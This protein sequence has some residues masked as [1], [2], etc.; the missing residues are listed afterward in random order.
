MIKIGSSVP[1]V[2]PRV[3]QILGLGEP[4]PTTMHNRK[5]VLWLKSCFVFFKKISSKTL[6]VEFKK[7]LYKICEIS[8]RLNLIY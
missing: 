6:R 3:N 5:Y 8:R 2:T 4:Y 1:G 7:N